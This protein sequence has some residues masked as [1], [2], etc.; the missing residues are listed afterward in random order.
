MT[1]FSV[2]RKSVLAASLALLVALVPQPG[3]NGAEARPHRKHAASRNFVPASPPLPAENPRR[4]AEPANPQPKEPE[5]AGEEG[6]AAPLPAPRPQQGPVA[7]PDGKP[8]PESGPEPKPEPKPESEPD[9]KPKAEDKATS[10]DRVYQNACPAIMR[11][12]VDGEL[13]PPLAEGACGERSPL[14]VKSVGKDKPLVF[15]APV[16]VN[17]SMATVLA[18]W[19]PTIQAEAVRNF[20]AEIETVVTGSDYQ[21]RKVNNGHVG[22]VSEH[23][24]A[25]ALDIVSFKFKNGKSTELASGWKGSPEERSFWSA[26]HKA[27]CERFMTVIGPDGDAAHATNLHLDL[28]CHGQACKSRICQ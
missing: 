22:R 13:V 28:G 9:E 26:L 17:C 21:C 4:Q 25:N 10:P 12:D 24:F 3:S 18:D 14:R 1:L 19:A 20:G 7:V 15:S 8:K 27:S 2:Q 11:G 6:A 16:T 5:S 23:A